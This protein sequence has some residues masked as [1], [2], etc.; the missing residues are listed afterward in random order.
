MALFNFIM[1]DIRDISPF[2]SLESGF[3][4]H[5]FG[6]TDSFYW[7]NVGEYEI[8]RYSDML[9]NKYQDEFKLPYVDYQLSR[10][11]EDFFEILPSIST[12]IPDEIFQNIKTYSNMDAFR[13]DIND[14]LEYKW[15]EDDDD[16]D[17]IYLPAAQVLSDRRLD[18]GYLKGGPNIWFFRNNEKLLIRWDCENKNEDGTKFWSADKGEHIV[19]FQEFINEVID[20]YNKFWDRMNEQVDIACN[21]WP[22]SD[23]G[24]DFNWLVNEHK[25][26]KENWDSLVIRLSNDTLK[27]NVD[28]R[29][30]QDSICIL[31]G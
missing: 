11:L 29:T 5:W 2:G 21:N 9:I 23:V 4:L 15:N 8:L 26:R 18:T 14:W 22:L 25:L 6:L 20:F 30:V 16:Y 31:R 3:S 24:I 1:K 10:F 7:L 27:E 28:W 17:K 19:S 12:P 13:N